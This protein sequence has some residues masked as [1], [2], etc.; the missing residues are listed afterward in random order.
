MMDKH[1]EEELRWLRTNL[2]TMADAMMKLDH[3]IAVLLDKKV[4]QEAA[5]NAVQE[6]QRPTG[7]LEKIPPGVRYL[8]DEE[9]HKKVEQGKKV[10]FAPDSKGASPSG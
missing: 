7:S 2:Q 6:Q 10:T 5:T 4:V 8:T 3:R 9:Y 1:Q